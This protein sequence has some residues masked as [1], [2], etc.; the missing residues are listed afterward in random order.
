MNTRAIAAQILHH[1]IYNGASLTDALQHP[2]LSEQSPQDQAFVRDLC[3]GSM[4]WYHRIDGILKHMLAKP[5]KKSD[6]DIECLLRIGLYQLVYQRTPDHASVNESVKAVKKLKKKPWAASLVNGV[7]R[8]FIREHEDI[9]KQVDK[10]PRHQYSFPRW[11]I[12]Q[13]QEAYPK[14][15]EAIMLASNEHPPMVLRV[16]QQQFSTSDYRHLLSEHDIKARLHPYVSSALVLGQATPVEQLPQFER[17]AVSVQDAAPQLCATLMDCQSGETILDACAAP[18]GKTCHLLEHTS[19]L[20]MLAIDIS[21]SRLEQVQQNL[22]RLQLKASLKAADVGDVASWWDGQTFD[23][24]LLDAPCSATGVIRRH[25]D[26]KY[27]RKKKDVEA[28]QQEQARLLQALWGTLK[29]GGTLL[30]ATCSILPEENHLQ[31]EQ[32]LQ[33]NNDAV[34]KEI[35]ANWGHALPYGRQILPA[36]EGMDGFYYALLEKQ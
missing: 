32:F 3:F 4:R 13:L 5:M 19:D 20:N 36:D 33:N 8:S 12:T 15:W 6:K 35:N 7:L 11:L 18:G 21:E 2:K 28:L 22:D 26:I 10:D 27:L 23:R 30:Y 17:G 24:I 31:I 29:S 9:L 1:V 34:H 14:D 16:N 25:P